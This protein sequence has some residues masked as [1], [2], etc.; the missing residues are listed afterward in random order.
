M[1][2]EQIW[3][4]VKWDCGLS[5]GFAPFHITDRNGKI[6]ADRIL[7]ISYTEN[8]VWSTIHLYQLCC[9]VLTLPN[10]PQVFNKSGFNEWPQSPQHTPKMVAIFSTTAYICSHWNL[11]KNIKGSSTEVQF[12]D[13]V[14]FVSLRIEYLGLYCINFYNS[15]LN[16]L[17]PTTSM[18]YNTESIEYPFKYDNTFN[19]M[20]LNVIMPYSQRKCQ[21]TIKTWIVT[22]DQI[23]FF[24][25]TSRYKS[26]N[27]SKYSGQSHKI[28]TDLVL[29]DKVNSW[30]MLLYI[31]GLF[32]YRLYYIGLL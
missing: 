7:L 23:D 13:D 32:L 15:F 17:L 4:R 21:N 19:V 29:C 27:N 5:Q 25:S 20:K 26:N 3:R 18:K 30:L 24:F 1:R 8:H 28:S 2:E 9:N 16:I 10:K 12:S 31:L 14:S 22:V 11:R 6:R